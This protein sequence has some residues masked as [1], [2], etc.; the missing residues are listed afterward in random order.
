MRLGSD[1]TG[2]YIEFDPCA[3]TVGNLREEYNR[4]ARAIDALGDNLMLGMSS[5]VDSQAALLSFL[6]QGIKIQTAF[7]HMPGYNDNEFYNL[8]KLQRA[9]QFEST[10]IEI[11][12]IKCK[13]LILELSAQLDIPPFQILHRQFLAELPSDVNFLQGGDG[14]FITF[15]RGQAHFY[16]GYNT[17][18]M[19]RNRAFNTLGRRGLNLLFDKTSELVVSA[20]QDDI[21]QSFINA[22]E[23]YTSTGV[24][25][26][27]WWDVYIKP[28]YY[29]KYWAR[30]LMYFP[31]FAGA[32]NID[33]VMQGVEH[34]YRE[35][36]ITVPV[37][38]LLAD[39]T[40]TGAR[41]YTK[42]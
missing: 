3:W 17:Y 8:L 1:N 28:M 16:E 6:D 21:M 5:G 19:T 15:I 36:F 24:K 20:L 4:R 7:L 13:S 35:K 23:M 26:V 34:R 9:W 22:H 32:E 41:Y 12:P 27:D 14:P 2:S 10:V 39:L 38:K 18:E 11:D 29:G 33:Y 37:D 42:S 30:D 40:T 25:N 31:K